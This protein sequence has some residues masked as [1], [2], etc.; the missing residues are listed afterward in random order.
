MSVLAGFFLPHSP[1]L[2]P[3]VSGDKE[4]APLIA[5][6]RKM[7]EAIASL[8]P[9]TVIV[10]TPHRD[11][12]SD[13]FQLADGEVGFGS[14]AHYGAKNITFRSLY[15]KEMAKTIVQLADAAS[16]PMGLKGTQE[17]YMDHGVMVP[18][19]FLNLYHRDYRLV[20]VAMSGLSLADHY[21]AGLLIRKATDILG[22]RA[23]VIASGDLAHTLANDSLFGF[24]EEG[25]KYDEII[26]RI[27]RSGNFGEALSIDRDILAR[28]EECAH[29]PL[30]MLSGT[31]DRKAVEPLQ[32]FYAEAGGTGY[33]MQGFRVIDDDNSRAFLEL[34]RQKEAL[35]IHD[36]RMNEDAIASFAREAIE[37]YV[38]RK[39]KALVPGELSLKP[40]QPLFI[41]L[42]KD[43]SLRG[44]LGTRKP[45]L[46]NLGDELL[47]ISI[48]AASKD[49]RYKPIDEG[50]LDYLDIRVELLGPMEKTTKAGLD[51]KK[52]GI[53][54][55]LGGRSA[56]VLP[57]QVG[58]KTGPEQ[59]AIAVRKAQ[60]D[61]EEEPRIYRFE[62]EVH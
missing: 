61:Q 55:S 1:S 16:F 38:K 24:R 13:Y 47:E 44:C 43:G 23:V 36:K 56:L 10:L 41:S 26:K 20:T 3:E 48:A 31:L 33:A 62:T 9:D 34:Y 40:S 27:L 35:R 51:P 28:A 21:R 6:Y 25:A 37:L 58:I 2:I 7:G 49:P 17:T 4:F 54:V 59:Y 60:I 50:E 57:N 39:R 15:D 19:Y 42:F 12:Y 14:F 45:R 29:R 5:E 52:Y 46:A 30:A 8:S 11:A 18:L 53:R 22:R 32:L